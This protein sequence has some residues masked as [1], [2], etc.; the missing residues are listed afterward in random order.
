MMLRADLTLYA[1]SFASILSGCSTDSTNAAPRTLNDCVVGWWVSPSS[2]CS[3]ATGMEEAS[4]ADCRSAAFT[5]YSADGSLT[6]GVY[7]Y[8]ASRGTMSGV[9]GRS[10]YV[11]VSGAVQVRPGSHLAQAICTSTELALDGQS[12]T[13]APAGIAALLEKGTA[14]GGTSF[15]SV[16]Q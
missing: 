13:R 2:P 8:S 3:T 4:A 12:Q 1:L 14:Q 15:A 6:A 9:F 7:S 10:T 16:P 11:V 5:N